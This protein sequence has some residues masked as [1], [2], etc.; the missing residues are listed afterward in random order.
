VPV[1]A[2]QGT[3]GLVPLVFE[4]V[5]RFSP[6]VEYKAVLNL[7]ELRVCL[8]N[9][10]RANEKGGKV[11]GYCWLNRGIDYRRKD[12][13]FWVFCPKLLQEGALVHSIPAFDPLEVKADRSLRHWRIG[14]FYAGLLSVGGGHGVLLDCTHAE[15]VTCKFWRRGGKERALAWRPALGRLV[16]ARMRFCTTVPSAPVRGR[17]ASVFVRSVTSV[18]S[19]CPVVESGAPVASVEGYI[20]SQCRTTGSC[21]GMR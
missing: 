2:Q 10:A 9:E 21:G 5:G 8:V 6:V 18:V 12:L 3:N 16:P 13:E 1:F 4:G 17:S 14:E 7:D 15:T 20:R 19:P 11:E